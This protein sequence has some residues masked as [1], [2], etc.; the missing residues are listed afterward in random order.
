LKKLKRTLSI[1]LAFIIVTSVFTAVPFTVS[2]AENS[3]TSKVGEQSGTTGDCTW[4]LDDEGTLTISGNGKMDSYDYNNPVPW[5]DSIKSVVIENGVTSIGSWAFTYSEGLTSVTIPDS[6][7][8]IGEFAFSDTAWFN[9]QPDGLVYAG[10]VAYKYKGKMPDNT[11]IFLKEG[12]NGITGHAFSYCSA[13][14]SITIPDSVTSIGESA[15]SGCTGLTNI[16]LPNSVTSIGDYVFYGCTGLTSVTIPGNVTSISNQAFRNCTGLT[17]FIIPDGIT[18]IGS[19]AFDGCTGLK[20]I[21]IPDSV[22]NIGWGA[23][24]ECTGLTKVN[25][26]D[27]AAW[28]NISYDNNYANPL[29]YAHNLYLNNELVTDLKIPDNV[30]DIGNYAFSECTSITNIEISDNVEFIS[31]YAFIGCTGLTSVT[32]PDSVVFIGIRAFGYYYDDNSELQKIDGFT[33]YGYS[34]SE[35]ERYALSKGFNFDDSKFSCTWTLDENGTLTISG[36]CEMDNYSNKL[37]NGS[38]ITTAPWGADIKSVIIQ[39]GVT[40]IGTSAFDGCTGLTNV[41]IPDSVTS[42]GAFAFDNCTGLTNVN[43]PDSVT[44]IGY[45]A[46]SNCKNLTSVTIPDSVTSIGDSAFSQCTGLT[47]ITIPESVTSIGNDA[48]YGYAAGFT[49]YGVKGSEAEKYA[50]KNNI[51]FVVISGNNNQT[52]TDEETNIS[53]TSDE[54]LTLKVIEKAETEAGDIVLGQ[55]EA[56]NS[57]YDISLLKDGAEVQPDGN[58]TVKIPCDIEG[59]KVYRVENDNTLTDMNAVY[60]NGYLVFTTDHFSV[61]VVSVP[62]T[63][64][65]GDV[66][67]DNVVDILDAII[68]Q[69]FTVDKV[70]LTDVQK[71]VADVNA[72]GVVDILDAT[73]IQKFT[74]D[75]ITEFKKKA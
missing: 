28:C 73:D 14:A 52:Y 24:E 50:N 56:I 13:L 57:V 68:I 53:V 67:G 9:N 1:L 51:P 4:T 10:K 3:E 27:I 6:V 74:V 19:S 47:S 48:F 46:F 66:N 18:S 41:Y 38:W 25:I 31:D 63:Y 15:F 71:D 11:S 42:I 37:Y 49:I 59:A 23:F 72:D 39:D 29:S 2:A 45:Y 30:V 61:Y 43:I 22:T 17:S 62:K 5:G 70:T 65:T 21:S 60:E 55:G 64:T 7:T 58:V 33:I 54:G 69:K 40:S 36:N 8:N 35:A 44:S 34:G 32:I 26:S 12:T 75:K 16:S 20:S